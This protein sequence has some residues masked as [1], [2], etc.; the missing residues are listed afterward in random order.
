MPILVR[1]KGEKWTRADD[2][3]FAN[4]AE[5]QKL[6]YE[7]PELI[8]P[9]HE[10]PA[11]FI[12]E[13]GL[14][15][16]GYT[17]LLGAD[18]DGNILIVETKLAKNHEV[19]R[20]VIGQILEYAAYLWRMSYEGF[21]NLFSRSEGK[22]IEDLWRL[23]TSEQLPEG[24]RE[25]VTANLQSGSFHLFIAVDEMNDELEKIISYVSSIGSGLKLQALELRTYRLGDLEILAPQHHGEFVPPATATN[26]SVEQALANCPDAHSRQLFK[27]LIENWEAIGHEVKPG[28]VGVAFKAE[29]GG[30]MQSIFW[31]SRGDLQGAFSV[32]SKNK[33]PAESVKAFRT[34]V[35]SLPGFDRSKFLRDSQPIAK[36]AGLTEM[37]IRQFVQE[38]DKLIQ[39][40]RNSIQS[41]TCSDS[42][43]SIQTE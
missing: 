15:G 40:W 9:H 13:A 18:A 30:S 43:S 38:S 31:A 11:L 8:S 41:S 29:V 5:L 32:L 7:G 36:M 39:A 21:D 22:S 19:R 24:F 25:T 10:H 14:P 26:I 28:Q 17:D 27:Q 2:V 35:A 1:H 33:A 6:L 37:E 42:A 4:E 12:R 3:R 23:K 20:K 16:S 34:A